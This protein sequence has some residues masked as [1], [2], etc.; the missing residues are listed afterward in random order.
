MVDNDESKAVTEREAYRALPG[1]TRALYEQ[2]GVMPPGWRWCP[3]CNGEGEVWTMDASPDLNETSRPCG[4]C[5][6]TRGIVPE[7]ATDG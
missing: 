6:A 3:E 7:E 4:R 2:R 1:P 5:E